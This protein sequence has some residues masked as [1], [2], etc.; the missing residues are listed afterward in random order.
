MRPNRVPNISLPSDA[1]MKKKGRGVFEERSAQ[2][3]GT[4]VKAVKYFDKRSVMFLRTYAA[5]FP[6]IQKLKYDSKER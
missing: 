6:T 5:V 2:M 1:E 4:K 3:H